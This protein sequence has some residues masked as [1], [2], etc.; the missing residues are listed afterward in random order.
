MF[1]SDSLPSVEIQAAEAT[2]EAA[3]LPAPEMRA[4]SA[5]APVSEPPPAQADAASS[6]P[7]AVSATAGPTPDA[8]HELDNRQRLAFVALARGSSMKKASEHAGVARSTLYRWINEH[9]GFRA[10][11]DRWKATTQMSAHGQVLALQDL[12]VEVIK[13]QLEFKRDAKLAE[14]ILEKTGALA[15]PTIGPTHPGRAAVQITAEQREQDAAA[16]KRARDAKDAVKYIPNE[17]RF[18]DP[19]EEEAK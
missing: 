9:P 6:P 12:A 17:F 2:A 3:S 4:P 8:E 10:A 15:P 13:E 14:R 5:A 16:A 18:T 1:E 19:P 7:P 11:Y